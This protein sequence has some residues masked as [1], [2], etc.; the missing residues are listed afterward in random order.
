MAKHHVLIIGGGQIGS[1][2]LQALALKAE[3]LCIS[4]VDPSKDQLI[5]AEERF[6]QVKRDK[7]TK[8]P[9]F[10]R[11]IS[12]VKGVVDLCIYATTAQ[13]RLQVLKESLLSQ[14]EIKNILFEKVLF[15]SEQQLDE[16]KFLIKENK[17]KAWVNCGRRMQ[18]I[19]KRLKSL[20]SDEPVSLETTGSNWGLASN[21]IHFIDLWFYLT[22]EKSYKLETEKLIPRIYTSKRDG[23][24][25]IGG[26]LIGFSDNSRFK[27]SCSLDENELNFRHT[28]STSKYKIVIDE[29][30][31]RCEI[32]NLNSSAKEKVEFEILPQSQLTHHI[33]DMILTKGSCDLITFFE[34]VEHHRP[35]LNGLL[36][37]FN[38]HGKAKYEICPIT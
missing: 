32:T 21:A 30:K 38:T 28:I 37:F 14:V 19:Y 31:G 22:G 35:L 20:L 25:E 33:A 1:R 27:L 12:E 16:A 13:H 29:L 26:T 15:Q 11:S 23:F 9:L 6:H 7:Q 36:S 24:K 10:L 5:L 8:R 18:P 34:S 2:H 3:G 4:V 17:I